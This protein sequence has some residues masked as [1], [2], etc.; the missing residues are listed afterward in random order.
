M[1]CA[2]NRSDSL[3]KRRRTSATS[4]LSEADIYFWYI[5]SSANVF[6]IFIAKFILL[7]FSFSVFPFLTMLE[8]CDC[9]SKCFERNLIALSQ[10]R[11]KML[12]TSIVNNWTILLEPIKVLNFILLLS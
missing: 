6:Y 1:G 2:Q 10:S 7:K 5:D 4:G 3:E 9:L 8:S 11:L 12:P